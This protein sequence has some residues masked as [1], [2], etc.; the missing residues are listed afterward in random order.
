MSASETDGLFSYTDDADFKK[1][2]A[3]ACLCSL[4]T[5][6]IVPGLLGL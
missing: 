6:F 5:L 4:G 2:F 1:K 3:I